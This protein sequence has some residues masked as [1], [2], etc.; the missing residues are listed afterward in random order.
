MVAGYF[1]DVETRTKSLQLHRVC[2]DFERVNDANVGRLLG[3]FGQSTATL[4]R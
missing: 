4:S 2:G 3:L 1:P